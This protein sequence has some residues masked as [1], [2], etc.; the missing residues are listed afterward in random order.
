M[1]LACAPDLVLD[2]RPLLTS[3][4]QQLGGEG[5]GGQQRLAQG[6]GFK[7]TESALQAALDAVAVALPQVQDAGG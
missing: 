1:V 5:G 4:L 7:A 2:M 6:G 3:L